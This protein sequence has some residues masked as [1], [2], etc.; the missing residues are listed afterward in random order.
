LKGKAIGTPKK[1]EERRRKKPTIQGRG[2]R[3]ENFFV[4]SGG[5]SK[6][7]KK[8]K[9]LLQKGLISHCSGGGERTRTKKEKDSPALVREGKPSSLA[10]KGE[11]RGGGEREGSSSSSLREKGSLHKAV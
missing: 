11:E 1:G 4:R 9:S 8:E 3:G 5:R 2:E 10:E 7:G 6:K